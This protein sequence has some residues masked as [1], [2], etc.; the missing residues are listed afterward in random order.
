M[1]ETE[2]YRSEKQMTGK[3]DIGNWSKERFA[4]KKLANE[5]LADKNVRRRILR[6]Q[7]ALE[8]SPPVQERETARA[9]IDT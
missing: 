9:R 1:M 5:R 6:V 8:G 4:N 7:G 3:Y 2:R